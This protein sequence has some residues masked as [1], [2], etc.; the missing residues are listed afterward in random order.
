MNNKRILQTIGVIFL[1]ITTCV[2]SNEKAGDQQK[3][4]PKIDN[5][6][7]IEIF[8]RGTTYSANADKDTAA[9]KTASL[10]RISTVRNLGL[11]CIAVDPNIIPYGSFIY[12]YDKNGN[13]MEGVAVD[14]GGAVK[15]RVAAIKLAKAKGYSKDSPQAKALVLDFYS[16]K[17]EITKHWDTFTVV[18]YEGPCFKFEM[19]NSQRVQHLKMMKDICGRK[20][21]NQLAK[22]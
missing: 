3:N 16:T 11:Q 2:F 14:T 1:L 17:G 8:A 18:L 22:R 10:I 6:K 20:S 5:L 7:Q 21:N 19:S 9:G 13:Y 12:G 15:K 4:Y